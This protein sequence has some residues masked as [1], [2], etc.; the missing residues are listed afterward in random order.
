MILFYNLLVNNILK[1]KKNKKINILQSSYPQE[2]LQRSLIIFRRV[3]FEQR[4]QIVNCKNRKCACFKIII[5]NYLYRNIYIGY[6]NQLSNLVD[7]YKKII[8]DVIQKKEN[9]RND[10]EKVIFYYYYLGII[11]LIIQRDI[12]GIDSQQCITDDA[13]I[14]IEDNIKYLFQEINKNQNSF[15]QEKL[16]QCLIPKF[17]KPTILPQYQ[18]LKDKLQILKDN[19]ASLLMQKPVDQNQDPKNYK[20]DLK[21]SNIYKQSKI[22]VSLDGKVAFAK[23][24]VCQVF[25]CEQ[26]VP[27]NRQISIHIMIKK[28]TVNQKDFIRIR[29]YY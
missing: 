26:A 4:K 19:M 8:I 2:K 17:D 1:I 20:R 13:I 7:R 27:N 25:L 24:D 21:F 15:N 23:E 29:R 18:I 6:L 28:Q 3:Q 14:Q 11:L 12:Q 16:K 22:Q 9:L 5:T 10:L